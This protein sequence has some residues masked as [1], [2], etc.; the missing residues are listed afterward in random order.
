MMTFALL[1]YGQVRCALSGRY[2][3]SNIV[4][5]WKI[6]KGANVDVYVLSERGT[7]SVFEEDNVKAIFGKYNLNLKLYSYIDQYPE[8]S[9]METEI[10]NNYDT[11][12]GEECSF[13]NID[14]Y[15]GYNNF[16]AKLWYRRGYLHHIWQS[17][18]NNR[19]TNYDYVIWGRFFDM[20]YRILKDFDFL[21]KNDDC[22]YIA[23]DSFF[24]GSESN[25]NKLSEFA[26]DISASLC[27]NEIWE[28][29][30]F[31]RFFGAID[32]CLC[33]HKPTYCSEVQLANYVWR[34]FKS[35]RNL[36]FDY[37]NWQPKMG[38]DYMWAVIKRA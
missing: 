35:Y 19:S 30:D 34:T 22:L 4:E 3:E 16:V 31:T 23:G 33:F 2:L 17:M 20:D 11:I 32:S 1:I 28:N 6:T 21:K 12:V 25:M 14:N 8:I 13:H 9:I 5:L 26:Q 15:K 29:V 27:G 24:M 38:E 36:R 18:N 7:N 37:N 10:Q